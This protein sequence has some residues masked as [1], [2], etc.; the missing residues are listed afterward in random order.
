MGRQQRFLH[1]G[2]IFWK[3]CG[4]GNEKNKGDKQSLDQPETSAA[5]AVNPTQ[6]RDT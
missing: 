6:E 4:E 5:N 3:E 1:D 2:A